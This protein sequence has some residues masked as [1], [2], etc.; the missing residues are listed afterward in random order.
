[1]DWDCRAFSA[2]RQPRPNCREDLFVGRE[3]ERALLSGHFLAYPYGEFAPTAL[4]E[5][6][7][8]CRFLLD[9]RRH[10]GSAWQVVSNFAIANADR[11]DSI[12]RDPTT[13]RAHS[14]AGPSNYLIA[15]GL[16]PTIPSWSR[17]SASLARAFLGQLIEVNLLQPLY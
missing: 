15:I 3:S 4:D 5:L 8:K 6:R 7:L 11:H 17:V 10:P 2:A 14:I 13:V 16:W 9:E 1:M 12:P